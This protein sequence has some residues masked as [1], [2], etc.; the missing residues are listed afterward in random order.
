MGQGS[1]RGACS[2]KYAQPLSTASARLTASPP[3][4]P[5]PAPSQAR[6]TLTTNYI[7]TA[8]LTEA[9]LPALAPGGRVVFVSSRAGLSSIVKDQGLRQR[10]ASG[11]FCL[12]VPLLAPGR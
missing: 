8:D 6:T 12:G 9:L 4:P 10:C 1:V 5:H 7:G 3:P 11:V 2:C